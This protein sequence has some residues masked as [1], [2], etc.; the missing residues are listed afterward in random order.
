MRKTMMAMRRRILSTNKETTIKM[1]I[2]PLEIMSLHKRGCLMI[3]TSPQGLK[4][5][6]I[7]KAI[8]KGIIKG[9]VMALAKTK[10]KGKIHS[11]N[12]C[13]IPTPTKAKGQIKTLKTIKETIK[14]KSPIKLKPI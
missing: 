12:K 2:L 3:L 13:R 11:Q 6:E 8:I 1:R 4:G 10:I 9:K 14:I 5:K 7:I